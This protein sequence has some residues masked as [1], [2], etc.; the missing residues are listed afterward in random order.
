MAG[1]EL[2][3]FQQLTPDGAQ[4]AALARRAGRNGDSR[5]H[6]CGEQKGRAVNIETGFLAGPGYDEASGR[7]RQDPVDLD[8]LRGQGIS[9]QKALFR[10]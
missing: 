9:Q 2:P 1:D 8:G 3:A 5:K 6:R 4:T 10:Q 7:R